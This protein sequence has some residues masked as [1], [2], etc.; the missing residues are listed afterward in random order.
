MR[1]WAAIAGFV[2]TVGGCAVPDAPGP[3]GAGAA[4]IPDAALGRWGLVPAD[5][6]STRGD[7]KGL[8]VV[9]PTRL[10]FYES[11]AVIRDVEERSP[12]RIV[13]TFAFTGEGVEWTRRIALEVEDGG[14]TLVRREL[15]EDAAPGAYEYV[16]CG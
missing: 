7:A 15:G 14:K 11:R 6:T 10:D 3:D 5:C 9:G 8:L 16:A 4:T 12:S 2:V 1:T 13:G